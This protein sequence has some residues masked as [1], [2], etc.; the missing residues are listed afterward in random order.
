M[1]Q[2]CN[3]DDTNY[4]CPACEREFMAEAHRELAIQ[5]VRTAAANLLTPV[6]GLAN[7][8][9]YAEEFVTC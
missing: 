4:V 8:P 1:C 3:A 5:N 2:T 7:V 6:F 9:T